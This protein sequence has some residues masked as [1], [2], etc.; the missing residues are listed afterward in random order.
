MSKTKSSGLNAYDLI[1]SAIESGELQPG[2][3]LR[4]TELAERFGLSRTPVREALKRLETQGLVAHE[5]HHG[6]IVS[7]LDYSGIVELYFLRETLEGAA[8]RLAAVHATSVEIDVMKEMVDFDRNVLHDAQELARRNR[9]FH[10]QLYLSSRNRYL[11]QM[12]ENLR[13]S[14]VLL[15]GTTLAAPQRGGASVDEH[16]DLVA[17]IAAHDPDAAEAAARR[18]INNALR[19]RLNQRLEASAP[20]QS[21]D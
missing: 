10:H 8:A 17:A 3:R 20:S 2:A 5:P 12:L 11:I 14:L 16:H 13:T 18:H 9:T 4:E 7:Q 19:V 21:V 6:A 1:L 15:A